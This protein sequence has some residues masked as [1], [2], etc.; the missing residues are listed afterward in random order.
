LAEPELR[1]A[2]PCGEK[3]LSF[4]PLDLPS[5]PQLKLESTT[6]TVVSDRRTPLKR[7]AVDHKDTLKTLSTNNPA[8]E[9]LSIVDAAKTQLS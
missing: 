9:G 2:K 5:T 7:T 3:S 4:T 6:K 8:K 1:A